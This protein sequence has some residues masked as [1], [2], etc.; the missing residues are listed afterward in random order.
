MYKAEDLDPARV[1]LPASA[2]IVDVE[3]V[4]FHSEDWLHN[5]SLLIKK[6]YV[7]VS[8]LK[9]GQS[10]ALGMAFVSVLSNAV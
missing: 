4:L 5:P 10:T 1:Q 9:F 2:G 7:K 6:E 3:D 8:E